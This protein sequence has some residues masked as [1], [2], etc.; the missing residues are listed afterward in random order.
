MGVEV[1]PDRGEFVGKGVDAVNGRHI[2][3]SR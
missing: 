1:A 3:L 2:S